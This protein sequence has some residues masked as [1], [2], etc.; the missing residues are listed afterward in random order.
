MSSELFGV[1][2][3]VHNGRHSDG[4]APR[5]IHGIQTAVPPASETEE[6]NGLE[7][8]SDRG[9]PRLPAEVL[10]QM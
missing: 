7:E 3:N 4:F 5:R 8:H 9:D 10:R 6:G 1:F 2:M